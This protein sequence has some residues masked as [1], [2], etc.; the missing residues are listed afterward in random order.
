MAFEIV[1]TIRDEKNKRSLQSVHLPDTVSLT[2]ARSFAQEMALLIDPLIKG[3]IERIGL[4]FMVTLPEGL[5]ADFVAGADV[6]EGATLIYEASPYLFRHRL[7]T[8]DEQFIVAGTR[9]VDLTDPDVSAFV[10]A[11]VD[12]LLIDAVQ[13]QPCEWREQDLEALRSA[14][15][16]FQ[17]SRR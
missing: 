3:K 13:V 17:R 10:D 9:E 7:P 11:M 6:E 2:N 12:G 5:K 1:Y 16:T 15:E 4:G 14:R 8:F